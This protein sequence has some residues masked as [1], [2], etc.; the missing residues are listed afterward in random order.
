MGPILF[1][2]GVGFGIAW[3]RSLGWLPEAYV[4][5]TV[6]F[7]GLA[8]A[9]AWWA[10]TRHGRGEYSAATAAA[11]ASAK[12]QANAVQ[13]VQVNLDSGARA[14]AEREGHRLERAEWWGEE[15]QLSEDEA[16]MVEG[17][18]DASDLY[19]DLLDV[20]DARDET[21]A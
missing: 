17:R 4:G 18:G 15:R 5:P 8:L 6:V 21:W 7:F 12:A 2:I 11:K 16:L 14:E 1:G 20:E 9:C 13:L 19:E 10:G 3:W